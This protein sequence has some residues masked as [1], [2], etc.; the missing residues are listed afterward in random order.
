MRAREGVIS[1][2]RLG[3]NGSSSWVARIAT[4]SKS[5]GLGSPI[6]LTAIPARRQRCA[7]C[8]PV[9][10]VL[11]NQRRTS[12][13]SFLGLRNRRARLTE[14]TER[15]KMISA[16][17]LSLLLWRRPANQVAGEPSTTEA[18]ALAEWFGEKKEVA[19][20]IKC[21]SIT[22]SGGVAAGR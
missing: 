8:Q 9:S 11:S 20:Y 4:Q 22:I 13:W 15:R 7:R 19:E 2:R 6:E 1:S 21:R 14:P 12:S 3:E 10:Q 17:S 18:R 5:I 16:S